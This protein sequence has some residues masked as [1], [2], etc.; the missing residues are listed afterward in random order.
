MDQETIALE[1][2]QTITFSPQRLREVRL[3]RFGPRSQKRF[4]QLIGISPQQMNAYE[5]GKD[6]PKPT[7]LA[8]VCAALQVDLLSLTERAP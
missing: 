3:E 6:R 8:R 1:E 5:T 4:A 2:I 7:T